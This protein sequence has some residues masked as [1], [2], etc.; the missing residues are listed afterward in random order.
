MFAKGKLDILRRGKIVI[1]NFK[2]MGVERKKKGEEE[3]K[4]KKKGI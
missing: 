2:M 3:K 4:E 1:K